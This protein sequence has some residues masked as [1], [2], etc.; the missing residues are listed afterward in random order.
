M[1]FTEILSRA[2]KITWKHK[3]LWLFGIV[4]MLVV[5]IYFP[6]A[7]VSNP[8]FLS[9]LSDK[10]A[11]AVD[12]PSFILLSG[13]LPFAFIIL[14]IPVS[15]ILLSAT[16]LGVLEADEGAEKLSFGGLIKESLPF[17]WRVLGFMAMYMLGTMIVMTIFMFF[18]MAVSIVTFGLGA[19]CMMPLFLLLF[20]VFMLAYAWLE[21]G[22]VAILGDHMGLMDAV[23]QAWKLIRTNFWQ[24]VLMII[25]IYFGVS[26]VSTIVMFPIM[27]PF[28]L[29]PFG[30]S[31]SGDV[32]RNVILVSLL[33]ML[34]YS[35]V[36]AI[37][38]GMALAFMKS[39][40]ALTYMRLARSKE[41]IS[42]TLPPN[43]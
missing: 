14:M 4:S 31:S 3:V 1:D 27:I 18:N 20:P 11:R 37:F 32:D 43:A 10:F 22:Q 28:F 29:V 13:L 23:N 35:P 38:Q 21:M 42:T 30:I 2:W 16:T 26:M 39:A 6:I 5:F 34:A 9:L 15:V 36:F 12:Q 33:C 25:V 8:V 40:W 17:F 19:L 24:I 7:F 41:T